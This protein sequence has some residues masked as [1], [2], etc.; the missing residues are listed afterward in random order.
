MLASAPVRSRRSD[1]LAAAQREFATAGWSGGRIERIAAAAAVNKQLLFHYFESKEGLFTSALEALLSRLDP[2]LPLSHDQPADEIRGVLTN[3]ETALR[4][5]PGL[6]AVV[7]DARGPGFPSA[8]AAV[9]AGW[10][11]ATLAR[12]QRAIAEGQ[13][14]G[15]FRDDIDPRAVASLALAAALGSSALGAGSDAGI[16]AWLVDYCAWR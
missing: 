10:R 12:L 4:D 15:Y 13:R 2:A 3:L 5:Q 14:R 8:A 9:V 6:L 16:G 7:A 11:T 1:I